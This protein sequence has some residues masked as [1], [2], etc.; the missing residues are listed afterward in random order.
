MTDL[1]VMK[2]FLVKHGTTDH[3]NIDY[4]TGHIDIPLNETGKKEARATAK[5]LKGKGIAEVFSSSLSRANGTA[6]I[7]ATELELPVEESDA[8]MEQS[9]GRFDGVPLKD[10]FEKLKSVG[11]FEKMMLEVGGEPSN[12]FKERVWTK[13]LEIIRERRI[14]ANKLIVAHGGVIRCIFAQIL[15]NSGS[16]VPI[17]QGTCC[18]NIIDYDEDRKNHF[19]VDLVNYT[20]HV[21]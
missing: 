1:T 6:R 11:D 12:E 10:Y 7:I 3:T 8:L 5:Y 21:R 19:L 13:F 17:S 2:I 9:S 18:V 14:E 16:W 15:C 20:D 4:T